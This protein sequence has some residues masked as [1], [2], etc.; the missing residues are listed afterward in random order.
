[1]H[2]FYVQPFNEMFTSN[3]NGSTGQQ[4]IIIIIIITIIITTIY[5]YYYVYHSVWFCL[6][7]YKVK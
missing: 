6:Q 4:I 2:T 7:F 1:M 5:Y 3:H